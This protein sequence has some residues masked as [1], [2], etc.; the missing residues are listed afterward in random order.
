[1]KINSIEFL[2]LTVFLV[3]ASCSASITEKSDTNKTEYD[4]S[5]TKNQLTDSIAVD[6]NQVNKAVLTSIFIKAIK[7]FIDVIRKKDKTSFDTL[8]FGNRKFGQPDDF[9]DIKFPENIN[10]ANII[11]L[12][13]PKAHSDIKKLYK[14]NSPMINLMGWVDKVKAE[15]VFVTFFPEFNHQYDCYIN[16][17]FNSTKK[18]YEIEKLTI[19]VLIN[20][21]NG[22]PE[23]F[24][25]YE[26]GKH[27]GD[28]PAK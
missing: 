18:E 8:F 12:S 4:S 27:I 26:G 25:I 7:D 11:L 20:D 22:E 2:G 5:L 21:K 9:P 14:K 24:A 6:C 13:I 23:H 10:G 28:K 19:E 15:F 16:Y 17:V 3:F 1:M